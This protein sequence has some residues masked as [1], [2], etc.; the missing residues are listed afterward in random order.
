[1]RLMSPESLRPHG[2]AQKHDDRDA[3]AV[4][5]AATRPTMRFVALQRRE[6]VDMQTPDRVRN[7]PLA[8]R[9][10]LTSQIRPLPQERGLVVPQGR[11][12][13]SGRLFEL[14]EAPSPVSR[15]IQLLLRDLHERRLPPANRI[16]TNDAEFA[17]QAQADHREGLHPEPSKERQAAPRPGARSPGA[18]TSEHCRGGGGPKD[19]QDRLSAAPLRTEL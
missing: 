17:A 3:E 9:T 18:I 4:A 6:Q 8:E 10:S 5:E 12:K 15:G 14:G 7:R 2:K 1:M 11:G 19:G 13:L 16:R